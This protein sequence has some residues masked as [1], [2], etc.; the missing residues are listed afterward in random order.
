MEGIIREKKASVQVDRLPVLPASTVLMGPLFSNLINNSLKYSKKRSR[1]RY[2]SGMRRRRPLY[3]RADGN[4][5]PGMGASISRIMALGLIRSTQSR[6][7]ICSA[8]Y[9]PAPNMKVRVSG[10]RFAR[11]SWKC[12]RDLFR[13]SGGRG[14]GGIHRLASAERVASELV[15]K[16]DDISDLN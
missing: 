11:R 4:R 3:P 6:Y 10:S 9:T 12:T 8:G 7:S 1:R 15:V 13:P 2:E 5:K 14:G 16:N